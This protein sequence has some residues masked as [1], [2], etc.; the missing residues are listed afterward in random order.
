MS[1]TTLVGFITLKEGNKIQ[2]RYQ[3]AKRDNYGS[4]SDE[5]GNYVRHK[6]NFI[7]LSGA[8]FYFL[9]F[10]YQGAAKNRSGDNLEAALVLA[11]NQVSMNRAQEAVKKKWIV[12]V[13]VWK[14]NSTTLE[15]ERKLTDEIW[16]AASLSYDATTVEDL[17]SSGID[18]VGSNAPNRVL[19]TEIVG[20]LPLTGQI[21]N[22]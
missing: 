9:P 19:T 20:H 13:E 4:L 7:L 14:V 12:K 16:T 21:R 2:G 22:K 3:N 17:L 5:S 8:K 15:V 18:A 6:D 1:I 11:N 10:I